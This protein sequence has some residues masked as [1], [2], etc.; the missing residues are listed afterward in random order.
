MKRRFAE[1]IEAVPM[2]GSIYRRLERRLF[3]RY[4]KR[5]RIEIGLHLA[6]AT[7]STVQRGIFAGMK[8]HPRS[9]WG[10]DQFTILSGQYE[11]ELYQIISDAAEKN[12]QCFIDI[13]C[14]NGFYA[15]GFAFI[16]KDCDVIAYDMNENA[17]ETTRLNAELNGV[18][19]RV[20]IKQ[21]ANHAELQET[22][23]RFETRF[24][25]V[26]IE[27]AEVDL[28]DPLKC[29]GLLGC[30]LLIEMHG[31]VK[32]V[33]A[34]LID[35]FACTHKAT[36]VA[37][38]P[39]NPFEIVELRCHFEDEAWVAISEGRDFIRENWLL[40][41]QNTIASPRNNTGNGRKA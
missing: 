8:I 40:L 24:V 26:D 20:L 21:T 7:D 6:N 25:L 29:P 31:R 11:K 38:L 23:E 9:S 28:I 18:S 14:A 2:V 3:F 13:G 33:A 17:R 16:T 4:T 5:L 35:R 37:R 30:D 27:G 15:V 39:R 10:A 1:A 32:E 36:M 34:I 12:Y 19:S 41:E 22:I